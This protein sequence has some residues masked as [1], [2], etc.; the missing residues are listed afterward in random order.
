MAIRL[1]ISQANQAHNAGPSGYTEKAGMDA[2]SRELAGVFKRDG[3]FVVKRNVAG[4][5][6]DTARENGLEA[7]RWGADYYVALHSNAGGVG[8]RGTFGY[9]HHKG[10]KGYKLAAGI[11]KEVSPLSPGPGSAL[12]AMPGFIELHTPHAPACLI[13]LEAHDWAAGVR[14]LT[15]Q[16]HAIA[17]AIYRGICRGLGLKPVSESAPSPKVDYRPLKRAAKTLAKQ[18]GIDHSKVNLANTKGAAFEDLL[19]AIADYEEPK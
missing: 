7:N 17:E 18:L 6:V 4:S 9:Y 16:K 11:V 14:F 10:S 2:I 3:R 5:R 1:Y 8:A 15:G 12:I 19:R 13:E